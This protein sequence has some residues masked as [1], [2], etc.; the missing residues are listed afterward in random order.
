VG[1]SYTQDQV[2]SALTG[3]YQAQGVT[4]GGPGSE[5]LIVVVDTMGMN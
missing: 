5:G 3:A 4:Y 2:N 1:H